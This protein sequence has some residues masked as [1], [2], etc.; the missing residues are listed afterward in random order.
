M[1]AF[2][3][4]FFGEE[5]KK[6]KSGDGEIVQEYEAVSVNDFITISCA[7][8]YADLIL[9]SLLNWELSL[10]CLIVLIYAYNTS[11]QC[12]MLLTY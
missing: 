9:V 7:W 4:L 1:P 8:N 3:I 2:P 12:C 6:V 11:S 5:L 10:L